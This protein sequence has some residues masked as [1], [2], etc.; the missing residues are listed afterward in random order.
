MITHNAAVRNIR[1]TT[2]KWFH[3]EN[4]EAMVSDVRVLFYAPT[5]KEIRDRQAAIA[6]KADAGE[7]SWLSDDLLVSLAGLPDIIDSKTKKPVKITREFV[8]SVDLAN[9]RSVQEAISAALVP[10]SE[11]AT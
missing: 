7:V 5:V 3:E 10:K 8:E 2:A 6:A 11:P 1:E 4:G 9:L